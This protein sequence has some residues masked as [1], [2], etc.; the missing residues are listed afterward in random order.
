[1]ASQ[2]NELTRSTSLIEFV[3]EMLR[4]CSYSSSFL[5]F[6]CFA[7]PL[8][9]PANCAAAT[10]GDTSSQKMDELSA[11]ITEGQ[12]L[13]PTWII[14]N[15]F[16][17][18]NTG[19][20]VQDEGNC[21]EKCYKGGRQLLSRLMWQTLTVVGWPQLNHVTSCE[22]HSANAESQIYTKTRALAFLITFFFNHYVFGW[23]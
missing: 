6:F 3:S 4:H 21:T 18:V 7:Y 2:L 9:V 16:Q 1:M 13:V 15:F 11:D 8:H 10:R 22:T 19:I 17:F 20:T 12:C 14:W 23:M 5:R